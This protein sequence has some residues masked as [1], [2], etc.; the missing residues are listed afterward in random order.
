MET[1]D[2][3]VLER[4]V[5]RLNRI[6]TPDVAR[7]LA[8]LRLNAKEQARLDKLARK[9]SEGKLSDAER[10]EYE[11]YV[12]AIDFLAILQAKARAVLKRAATA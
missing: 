11:T 8:K 7:D 6:L 1:P 5:D 3:S 2:A 9:S 10:S 12:F 4:W